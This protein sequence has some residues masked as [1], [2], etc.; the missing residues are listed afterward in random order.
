[1]AVNRQSLTATRLQINTRGERPKARAAL[2]A[3]RAARFEAPK[4]PKPSWAGEGEGWGQRSRGAAR[5]SSP[6]RLERADG[7]LAA[8]EPRGFQSDWPGTR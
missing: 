3:V 4:P 5:A 2:K 6:A 1:M 7:R 8:Q